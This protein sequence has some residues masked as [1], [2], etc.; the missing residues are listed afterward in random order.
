MSPSNS[1]AVSCGLIPL[2]AGS[3]SSAI[4]GGEM[5]SS[6]IYKYTFISFMV[7]IIREKISTGNP[8]AMKTKHKPSRPKRLAI[9]DDRFHTMV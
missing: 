7:T 9:I 1:P 3:V 5:S 2:Y 4:G 8:W 6:S